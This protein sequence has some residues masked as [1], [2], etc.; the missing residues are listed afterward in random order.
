MKRTVCV[1]LVADGSCGWLVPADALSAN[2]ETAA[3]AN[4]TPVVI[5]DM[6]M[7]KQTTLY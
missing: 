3:T 1:L 2:S 6:R 7:P 5:V 4:R